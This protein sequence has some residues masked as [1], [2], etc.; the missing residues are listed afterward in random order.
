MN[1][2]WDLDRL[3]TPAAMHPA[4]GFERPG[5]EAFFFENGP[6]RGKPTRVF[7]WMG[8]PYLAPGQTCP[9]MVL[10]HG[11]GGTAFDEWVRIWNRR[12]YAAIVF[13]QCGCIPEMPEPNGGATHERHEHGGPPGWGASFERVDDPLE[14]QWQYH[15]VAAALRAH[16]LLASL[17]EVDEGRIGVTGISW[18][19]YLSCLVA[20]ADP[21]L[22]CVIPVYGCGFLGDNSAFSEMTFRTMD[23]A[24][25]ARWLELWDPAQFLPHAKMP[26]CWLNG[27]N[28]GVYPLDSFQKSYHL[29]DFT[30]C[31]R[32]GMGHSHPHG[33]APEEIGVFA[34]A[35]LR[36]GAPLPRILDTGVEETDAAAG[37][38][39]ATF[40][41]ARPVLRAELGY[42]RATGYWSDRKYNILPIEIEPGE[43]RVEAAIP[44]G[45]TVCF[46]NLF[47]DR[48]CVSSS[49]PVVFHSD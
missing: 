38:L 7:A 47:D 9:A 4:P 18:G 23:P 39:W 12:G 16:T 27:T 24:A 42:T 5:V 33:W 43:T 37:Q 11:G 8:L 29:T 34:D 25:V 2:E 6:Y 45:T 36:G 44:P 10:L 13:D 15:A 20:A 31:L 3:S 30:A 17:P 28:D 35:V 1:V 49:D 41:S 46:F 48:G 32:V 14:E 22:R 19:G 21:R 40:Q 26:F